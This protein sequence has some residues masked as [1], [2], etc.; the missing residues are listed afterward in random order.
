MKRRL[1]RGLAILLL[2][3]IVVLGLGRLAA[4]GYATY[5]LRAAEEALGMQN[6][7]KARPH[8]DEALKVRRGSYPL[9]LLAARVSRQAGDFPAADRHL[10]RYRALRGALTEDYQVERLMYKAQ[11]GRLDDVLDGLYAYLKEDRP[12]APLVLECLCQTFLRLEFPGQAYEFVTEWLKYQPDNVQALWCQGTCLSRLGAGNQAVTYLERALQRDPTRDDIRESLALVMTDSQRFPEALPLC[13]KIR[14]RQPDNTR[15]R[16]ILAR[17]HYE[18][19]EPAKA[20][21]I[22][23]TL[24]ESDLTTPETL[25]ERGRLALSLG[26]FEEAETWLQKALRLEPA[27]LTAAYQ[28]QI[29]LNELE[30]KQEAA[31]LADKIRRIEADERRIEQIF[32]VDLRKGPGTAPLY[33]ELGRLMMRTGR[34]QAAIHWLYKGLEMDPSN[35]TSQQLLADYW[36][37]VGLPERA[38]PHRQAL[39]NR[40]DAEAP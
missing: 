31:E 25:L 8:L 38:A 10:N 40:R 20:R 26:K 18:V 12:E 4:E 29:C 17:C 9:L 11:T 32:T 22:L 15:V 33:H 24:L 34:E 39:M 6:Y 37:R 5:H 14:A 23:D 13:E 30:K 27:Y 3:T 7:Q 16:L 35:A 36:E 28:L 1:L 2:A 21:E 19:G